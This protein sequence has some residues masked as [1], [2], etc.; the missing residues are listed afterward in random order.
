MT[1]GRH[2]DH[3][4]LVPV[5]TRTQENPSSDAVQTGVSLSPLSDSNR[6]P[7]HYKTTRDQPDQS[8][9]GWLSCADSSHVVQRRP[10]TGRPPRAALSRA[11]PPSRARHTGCGSPTSLG[12]CALRRSTYETCRE[13]HRR[14]VHG[15]STWSVTWVLFR[16]RFPVWLS[17]PSHRGAVLRRPQNGKGPSTARPGDSLTLFGEPNVG[18]PVR[19]SPSLTEAPVRRRARA[20]PVLRPSSVPRSRTSRRP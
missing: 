6:R 17:L 14:G 15:T 1:A 8:R 19:D 20:A 18:K 10:A 13:G 4:R 5:S 12:G 16:Y 9:Y 7:T 3:L 11:L 2:L